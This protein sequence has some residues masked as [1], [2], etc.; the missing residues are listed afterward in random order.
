MYAEKAACDVSMLEEEGNVDGALVINE[1]GR[2]PYSKRV[3]GE[4]KYE[5]G[6]FVPV[7]TM[8]SHCDAPIWIWKVLSSSTDQDG[9]V[10][11]SN[12]HW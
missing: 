4:Y 5:N 6:S 9:T 11:A 7:K 8:E 3:V 2:Q 1:I 10:K 12:I